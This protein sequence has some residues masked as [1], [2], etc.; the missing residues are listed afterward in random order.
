M[1]LITV[2][3]TISLFAISSQAYSRDTK[4]MLSIQEAMESANFK[5]K[6]DPS[7]SFY[8]GKQSHPKTIKSFGTFPTNKKTNSLNKSDE[9]ACQ[10]VLL[11]ALLALQKRAIN[12]GANAVVDIVSYY[13]RNTFSSE[14]EYECHAGTIMSGVALSGT[15][16]KLAK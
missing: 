11:S 12:E 1:R 16:V 7:I 3:L 4:H 13:K 5:E 10:W 6:L 15:V 14:T 9:G 8:F 2:L